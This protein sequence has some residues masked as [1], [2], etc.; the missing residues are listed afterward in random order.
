MHVQRAAEPWGT[1]S[2]CG[3]EMRAAK[4]GIAEARSGEPGAPA[5]ADRCR[6]AKVRV[7]DVRDRAIR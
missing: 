3:A 5:G 6:V 2:A 4:T 7:F 1:H